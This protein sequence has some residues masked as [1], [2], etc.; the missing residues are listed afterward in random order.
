MSKELAVKLI[1]AES[2]DAFLL[3]PGVAAHWQTVSSLKAEVD[4]LIGSD[5]NAAERLSERIEEVALA[6]GDATSKAFAEASRARV[7]H[8][9]GRYSEA[10]ALYQSATPFVFVAPGRSVSMVISAR[11]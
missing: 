11:F 3:E 9:I 8:H 4:R 7:L 6:L 2:A 1:S 10:D 5:L